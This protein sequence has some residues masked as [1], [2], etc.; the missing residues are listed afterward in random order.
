MG[1]GSTTAG[2][3]ATNYCNQDE[4]GSQFRGTTSRWLSVIIGERSLPTPAAVRWMKLLLHPACKNRRAKQRR[5]V[6]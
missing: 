1:V 5:R 2:A 4:Q 3:G 6:L